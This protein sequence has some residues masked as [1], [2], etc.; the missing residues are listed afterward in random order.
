MDEVACFVEEC[1][2]PIDSDEPWSWSVER[3]EG[4]AK[5]MDTMPRLRRMP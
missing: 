2:Y 4:H 1:P 3:I 5:P